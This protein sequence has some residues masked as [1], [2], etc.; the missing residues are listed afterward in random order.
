M[1]ATETLKNT[2]LSA[3]HGSLSAKM[4]PFAGWNMPIQYEGIIAETLYT[5][6]AVTCF[7][8][9][10]MGE[11]IVRGDL[12]KSGLDNIISGH[13]D[14]LGIGSCRYSSILNEG[15]GVI[16][17]LIVYRKAQ[18]EWMI[19]INA[20]TI[21][22]D[23]N[24]FLKHLSKNAHFEDVSCG[25]GKIDLQG[26]LSR[27]I[28]KTIAPGAQGL[29]YYTFTETDIMGEKNI[30]S[31]TGYTGELG[32]ELYAPAEKIAAIW[33]RLT[34]DKRVKP[35][36]LGARDVL[37]LEMGYSLYGQD[38]DDDTSPLEAGLEKFLDLNKDFIGKKAL[39]QQKRSGLR[40][41]RIFF[42]TLSR[43]SPRHNHNIYI[44][45]KN[46]GIVT[47]GTFSPHL[48]Y[49]IGM[50]FVSTPLDAGQAILIGDDTL[51]IEAATCKKPFIKNTSIKT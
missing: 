44:S 48:G 37:R 23:K 2:P 35:A 17:D 42:K 11:F 36:G 34:S 19:V 18:E 7:D 29:G 20:A 50:G 13:I 30:V 15:G 33:E 28:L 10:H 8:I 1:D 22:K 26:P 38:I 5:R 25:L 45:D 40:R 46:T 51:K 4:A 9:C 32:F 43:R 39:L 21:E 47:S 3:H 41:H 14:N 6:Q 27:E 16:D 12:K 24:H 49:G 31:R